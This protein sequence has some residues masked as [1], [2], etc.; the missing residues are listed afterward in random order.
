MPRRR[1]A[2]HLRVA[3]RSPTADKRRRSALLRLSALS[4]APMWSILAFAQNASD[5]HALPRDALVIGNSKYRHLPP[6]R[7]PGND[8]A[9]LG[10]LLQEIGFSV[11]PLLDANKVSMEE[12]IRDYC[13]RLRKNRA[14]GLFYFAGHG[15]Q[16]RWR[17]FLIPVDASLESS[18][19]VGKGAVDLGSLLEG[20]RKAGNP[21]N[22]VVLDAC[23]DNPFRNDLVTGKGLS[24]VDAP[25]GTFLAYATSP[26]NAASDGDGKNGLYTE[27]LLKELRAPEAK[28]EDVFKRV[29]LSVRRASSGM[30]I[31]WESTSL[32]DDFYFI[33]PPRIVKA[34]KEERERQFKEEL[35]LWEKSEAT[36]AAALRSSRDRPAEGR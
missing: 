22:V 31:P 25:V 6:L 15:L 12:S 5:L 11:S 9:A 23:R 36:V 2:R 10:D 26:G 16:L 19:D 14:I 1:S 30:Q 20:L 27:F 4:L 32:E 34:S 13:A 18:E 3:A 7:N 28:I 17:N 21:M 29:R 24:Q 33:P 8:A 35:A